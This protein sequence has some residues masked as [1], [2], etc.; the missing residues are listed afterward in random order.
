[1]TFSVQQIK[2]ECLSYIKEFGAKTDEWA[3]GVA[4]D[5]ERALFAECGID[6]GR[7]IWLWKPALSAAAARTVFDFMVGR[8]RLSPVEAPAS[9]AGGACVFMYRRP[10][11]DAAGV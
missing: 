3:I 8:Y 11:K 1:M 9:V 7:D 10:R 5:P 2:F 4:D 6:A